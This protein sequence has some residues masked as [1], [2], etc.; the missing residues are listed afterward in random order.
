MHSVCCVMVLIGVFDVSVA[1]S[2]CLVFVVYRGVL[3]IRGAMG[4][5]V[6]F[7]MFRV[8]GVCWFM[9]RKM[10]LLITVD[11]SCVL[12]SFQNIK[13]KVFV[14]RCMLLCNW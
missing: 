2:E 13:G 4:V 1:R 12:E 6:E 11:V 8:F 10:R 5:F 9:L 7:D 14:L 3:R